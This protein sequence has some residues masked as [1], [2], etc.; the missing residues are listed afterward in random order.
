MTLCPIALQAVPKVHPRHPIKW[1]TSLFTRP[2]RG[3]GL[4][5]FYGAASPRRGDI[6][7]VDPVL[8]LREAEV[9]E[10][11]WKYVYEWDVTS[12]VSCNRTYA[13]CLGHGSLLNHAV[14]PNLVYSGRRYKS[15]GD[16]IVFKAT[17]DIDPGEELTINYHG[18]PGNAAKVGFR[19]RP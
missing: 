18:E 13:L 3:K 8:V 1:H 16:A 12:A 5:V 19:V 11:L 4:G 9:S 14:D 7:F 10:T 17:R 15:R 2:V 6:I